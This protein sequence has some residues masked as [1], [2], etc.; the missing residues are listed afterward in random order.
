MALYAI[1]YTYSDDVEA[2]TAAKPEHRAHLRSLNEQGILIASGPLEGEGPADALIVVNADDAEG[3]AALSDA[4]PI[5]IAG[6]VTERHVQ[7]WNVV[8]GG[9]GG[10]AE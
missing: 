1:T 10:V 2:V 8:I 7:L 3:A 9:I 6:L 4:D 5:Y